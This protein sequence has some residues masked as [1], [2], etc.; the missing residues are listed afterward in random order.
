MTDQADSL[1]TRMSSAEP[2]G[3]AA[4]N[5]RVIVVAS[6]KGGV[7]K[8]NFSVNFAIG[9]QMAGYRPVVI[10]TDIGFANIDLLLGVRPQ[11][12]LLDVLDGRS[13][14]E[15]LAVSASGL[16]FL[17]AG[18]GLADI[19]SLQPG[20]VDR[21]LGALSQLQQRHDFIIIDCGAGLGSNVRRLIR[22]A[23]DLVLVTTPEPT[24]IADAYALLKLLVQQADLSSTRIVVN[25]ARTFVEARLAADKLMTVARGFL[26]VSP[27][28]LG[29]ILEDDVVGR[30][31][32]RQEAFVT[33]YPTAPSSRCILQLVQN[34]VRVEGGSEPRRGL[35]AF[36]ERLTRFYRT[37][38]WDSGH[39]A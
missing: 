39:S 32:M 25:R 33:A 36:L 21:L 31:V 9:L 8:S 29:Y 15:T 26:N 22:A 5:A 23:D 3:G 12:T 24:A 37:G 14:W 11:R 1:R 19:H 20:Q 2:A 16:P 27:S 4:Q 13:I 28:V 10:D 30:S 17:S 7:G 34:Y 38:E 35:S 18:S 6:G